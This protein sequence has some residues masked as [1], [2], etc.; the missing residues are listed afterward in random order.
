MTTLDKRTRTSADLRAV[1]ITDFFE[2]ELPAL[3]AERGA[4]AIDG[5]TEF[6]LEPVTFVTGSGTWTLARTENSFSVTRGDSGA[7]ALKLSDF[8]FGRTVIDLTTF[9]MQKALK[10]AE[11]LRGDFDQIEGWWAVL[12]S[13][14]DNRPFTTAGSIQ[15]RDRDGNA[16]D[17][18]RKFTPEDDDAEIAH[19][20]C[21]AG[22]LHLSGW[23]DKDLMRQLSED[24]DRG[25][26]EPEKVGATWMVTLEDGTTRPTRIPHLEQHSAAAKQLIESEAY[27][28]LGRLTN[29]GFRHALDVEAAVRPLGVTSGMSHLPWH[30]DCSQGLHSYKC[31]NMVIGI[32]VTD[33][34][35]GSAQLGVLPGSHRALMPMNKVYPHVGLEPAFLA[36]EA[37]DATVHLSCTLHTSLPPTDSVRKVIYTGFTLPCDKETEAALEASH[38][39]REQAGVE[40]EDVP[41]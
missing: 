2:R 23:F 1:D 18:T 32:C 34:G 14:L 15:L 3:I 8:E 36:V 22:F 7:S 30:I 4:Q 11:H 26:A 41:A 19:F 6:G 17:L 39:E 40:A 9:Q 24:I 33:A 12:R 27:L 37:G 28:R 16:L 35:P 25:F 20:L 31:S 38:A 10:K 13:L 21:E 29:E 5:A